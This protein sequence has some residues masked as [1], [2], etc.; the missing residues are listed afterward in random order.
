MTFMRLISILTTFMAVNSFAL[1][2]SQNP[3][4]LEELGF[5]MEQQKECEVAYYL[6]IQEN[7]LGG[8]PV[9]SARVQCVD[10]RQ[11]DAERIGEFS[12]FEIRECEIQTC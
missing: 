4:W 1:A 11:Y 8:E 9:Y 10:G 3:A 5:A 2:Q 6:N 12:D 7:E